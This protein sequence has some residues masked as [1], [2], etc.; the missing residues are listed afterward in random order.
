DGLTPAAQVAVDVCECVDPK[1]CLDRCERPIGRGLTGAGG[2]IFKLYGGYYRG[3]DGTPVGG[4]ATIGDTVVR[5]I[6]LSSNYSVS[7]A[8]DP[9]SEAAVEIV[10]G[11]GYSGQQDVALLALTRAANA[12]TV[13]AGLSLTDAIARAREVA[14]GD[15]D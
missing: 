7:L 2:D 10:R 13:L 9:I 11:R 14:T 1:T 6:T 8:I 12:D 4:F 5:G 3:A 15:P